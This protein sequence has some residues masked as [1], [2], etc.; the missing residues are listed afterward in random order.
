MTYLMPHDQQQFLA[1]MDAWAYENS[2]AARY[3]KLRAAGVEPKEA[4]AR[5]RAC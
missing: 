3:L 4:Y 2:M 5:A 1:D